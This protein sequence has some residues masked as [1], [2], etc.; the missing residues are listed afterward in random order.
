MRGTYNNIVAVY[1]VN[2][3]KNKISHNCRNNS[4]TNRKVAKRGKL[5]IPNSNV[6]DCALFWFGILN[7]KS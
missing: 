3:M 1:V 2:K 4:K 5:D 7:I 6:N